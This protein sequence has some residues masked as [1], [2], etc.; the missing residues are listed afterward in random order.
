MSDV[1]W[2]AIE[3][4]DAIQAQDAAIKENQNE[5]LIYEDRFITITRKDGKLIYKGKPSPAFFTYASID[6]ARQER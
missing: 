5:G 3:I 6:D 2:I 1:D 4:S